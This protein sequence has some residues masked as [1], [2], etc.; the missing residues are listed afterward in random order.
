[1]RRPGIILWAVLAVLFG[2]AL[3]TALR[4]LTRFRA[5]RDIPAIETIDT[6]RG[7]VICQLS[8]PFGNRH[9]EAT[10]AEA[11]GEREIR[12][13]GGFRLTGS[14]CVITGE[15]AVLDT[16]SGE[17]RDMCPIKVWLN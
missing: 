3:G 5:I 9:L 6:A 13:F 4:E 15:S 16:L 1:M 14:D 2:A 12:V 11:V 10:Y 17:V 7:P 8:V